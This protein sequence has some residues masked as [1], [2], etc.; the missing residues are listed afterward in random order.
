M[1]NGFEL[2]AFDDFGQNE[3]PKKI[4]KSPLSYSPY[5]FYCLFDSYHSETG[6]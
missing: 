3:I 4:P 2:Q 5:S 6:L 1:K